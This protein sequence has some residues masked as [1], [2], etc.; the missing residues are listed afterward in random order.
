MGGP[1][2]VD[3]ESR[4]E[5]DN[6]L[7]C[8]FEYNGQT[9]TSAEH[10]FQAAKFTDKKYCEKIRLAKSGGDAWSL[11]NTRELPLRGDWELIKVKV[12]YEANLA[13]FQ[14]NAALR[15]ALVSTRGPIKAF[16]FAYWAK[17]NA[18][19]LERIRE[20]LR[21]EGERDA[22]VLA[23]RVAAMEAIERGMEVAADLLPQSGSGGSGAAQA[24]Q[25]GVPF[26]PELLAKYSNSK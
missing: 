13:K 19:L 10:A 1:C 8:K 22:K 14:Q 5:L 16:G 25:G 24:A 20:E 2:L 21:P 4:E 26:P 3:G 6:F 9:Y 12:M 23:A 11:G 7:E 17:W 15:D 18:I